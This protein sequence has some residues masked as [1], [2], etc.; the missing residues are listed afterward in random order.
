MKNNANKE[1]IY[2]DET[3]YIEAGSRTEDIKFDWV[4]ERFN[5][6]DKNVKEGEV[7]SKMEKSIL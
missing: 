3:M 4:K 6:L 1:K 7:P 5:G 2:V